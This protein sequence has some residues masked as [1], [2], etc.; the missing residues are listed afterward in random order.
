MSETN[1]QPREFQTTGTI[2]HQR[3]F[4]LEN[5]KQFTFLWNADQTKRIIRNADFIKNCF[6]NLHSN[7]HIQKILVDIGQTRLMLKSRKENAETWFSG[8]EI[9]DEHGS[10]KEIDF[11]SFF[12][13]IEFCFHFLE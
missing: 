7:K 11:E 4:N 8:A 5:N 2:R 6:I 10:L 9:F 1:Q 13:V 3:T 12:P